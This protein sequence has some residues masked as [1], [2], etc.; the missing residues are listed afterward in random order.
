M[1]LEFRPAGRQPTP[2]GDIVC[3]S[4]AYRERSRCFEISTGIGAETY[5]VPA[6]R[7]QTDRQFTD[8]VWQLQGKG[9]MKGQ[10]FSDF[11]ECLSE[12]IYR[13]HQCWPQDYFAVINAANINIDRA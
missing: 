1:A 5:D 7:L 2:R 12:F 3:G 6:D 11:F 13:E 8:W 9:W 10:R 4:V